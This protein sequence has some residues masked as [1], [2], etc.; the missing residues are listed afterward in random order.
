MKHPLLML[1]LFL[2]LP[3]FLISQTDTTAAT[4][5]EE[6]TPGTWMIVASGGWTFP[7]EPP[8]F[9]EHFKTDYNFGGGI[10]Y[11]MSPGESGYG[12]VSLLLHYYN[13][14]FTRSGFRAANNLPAGTGVYGYQGDVYTGM[15]QFRGVYSKAEGN[16]AP[17]FT[18][19]VGVYH[20][21]LPE[22]GLTTPPTVLFEEEKTT[23]FGWYVGLGVDAPLMERYTLFFD[24]K[25]LM[26]VQGTS[27]YR[28]FSAGGGIRIKI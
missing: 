25:F 26:G 4:A 21:A 15:L 28:L 12:E 9:T 10:A 14:L 11:A 1:A 3:T 22:R 13:V 6:T 7:T 2:T 20:I 24:G 16:I 19:G 8:E 17:Y 5:G 27:G 23:T 18:T